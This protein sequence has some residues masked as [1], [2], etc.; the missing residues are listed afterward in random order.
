MFFD[1]EF[2]LDCHTCV[3]ANTT[4]CSDCIVSHLLANDDGPIELEPVP[5]L[6]PTHALDRA[7]AMFQRAGLVDDVPVFVSQADFDA[8][9]VA[10]VPG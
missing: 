10:P 5:V 2:S 4:A 9:L 1:D 7:V 8:G 6:S 3:A